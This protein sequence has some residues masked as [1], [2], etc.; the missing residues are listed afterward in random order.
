MLQVVLTGKAQVAYSALSADDSSDYDKVK[1]AV[2]RAYELVPEAYR[3]KFRNLRKDD[4]QS[5]MEF[6]RQ[7]ER[8]FDDWCQSRNVEDFVALKEL[9]LLEEFKNCIHRE[10][11]T[12]L[13]EMQVESLETAAKVSDEYFLTHKQ[14]RVEN[15]SPSSPRV[16][17]NHSN[18]QMSNVGNSSS[19][20]AGELICFH[21][22]KKGHVKARCYKYLQGEKNSVKGTMLV[23][24]IKNESRMIVKGV[25][26]GQGT[27]SY[28]NDLED[29]KWYLSSGSVS[30]PS[31]SK[32]VNVKI[33][34]DTGG[35]QSLILESV[36]P[37]GMVLEGRGS[38]LVGGFPDN[39]VASPL[40]TVHLNSSLVRGPVKVAVVKVLPFKGVNF[41]LGN[42][43]ARNEVFA[44][45]KARYRPEGAKDHKFLNKNLPVEEVK[46]PVSK[47]PFEKVDRGF[48]DLLAC[49]EDVLLKEQGSSRLHGKGSKWSRETFVREQKLDAE[50]AYLR[51]LAERGLRSDKY[52]V[53]G[54]LLFRILVNRGNCLLF[55]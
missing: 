32:K 12:H 19:D 52:V 22:G 7:K 28:E 30:F 31:C 1:K 29:F 9:M 20:N 36:L 42:D 33:L 43:L 2:L 50:V 24:A 39:F 55:R 17:K 16:R 38:V 26:A 6:A 45:A 11:K 37:K 10:I 41:V 27:G 34:R 53:E 46:V 40:V 15:S 51:S 23:K 25:S 48:K 3:Q 13:E 21:C 44:D 5:Y 14:F 54:D 49:S 8:L 47:I 4:G 35:N 18:R